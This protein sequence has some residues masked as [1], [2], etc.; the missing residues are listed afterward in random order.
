M[1]SSRAISSQS[2]VRARV[3]RGKNPGWMC[4]DPVSI[5]LLLEPGGDR[6]PECQS[7]ELLKNNLKQKL[8]ENQQREVQ[9]SGLRLCLCVWLCLP[10]GLRRWGRQEQ[11][12]GGGGG[13]DGREDR[14]NR[15]EQYK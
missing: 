6:G 14:S 7:K 10:Y 4:Y 8:N 1:V 9:D 5:M 13:G 15:Q 11:E 3:A 2:R 12:S